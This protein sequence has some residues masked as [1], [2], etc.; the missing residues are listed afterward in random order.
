ME[1]VV[2]EVEVVVAARRRI[3]TLGEQRWRDVSRRSRTHESSTPERGLQHTETGS[4]QDGI[5]STV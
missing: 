2:V 3:L 1:A 5:P 4:A